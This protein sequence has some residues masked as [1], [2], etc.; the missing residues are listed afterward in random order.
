MNRKYAVEP[1]VP[2][3]WENNVHAMRAN[4]VSVTYDTCSLLTAKHSR[5]KWITFK[6][7]GFY[8]SLDL[9][10]QLTEWQARPLLL[11]PGLCVL[12]VFWSDA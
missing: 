12:P 4:E 3:S 11:F 1:A 2:L 10:T 8:C 6:L 7:W 9:T 5:V